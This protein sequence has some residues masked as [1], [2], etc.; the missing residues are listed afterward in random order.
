LKSELKV[1]SGHGT[2]RAG[3]R[4]EGGFGFDL[5]LIIFAD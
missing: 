3:K 2:A 5:E 1:N 4:R